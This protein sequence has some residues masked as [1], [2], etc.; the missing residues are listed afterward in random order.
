M[1]PIHDPH[2][3]AGEYVLGTLSR[4]RRREVDAML[5]N[6][7]T[8]RAAVAYWEERLLPLTTLVEP[9]APSNVLWPRIERSLGPVP[10]PAPAR[11]AAP[12][13][14]ERLGL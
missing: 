7:A 8:L 4:E 11:A 9:A 13:W 6:D 10:A 3:Q 5:P 2:A 1:N 14:W 12:G